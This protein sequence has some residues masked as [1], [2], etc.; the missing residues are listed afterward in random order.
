VPTKTF[1]GPYLPPQSLTLAAMQTANGP[2]SYGLAI[3]QGS[4]VGSALDGAIRDVFSRDNFGK[5][6]LVWFDPV[7]FGLV[8]EGWCA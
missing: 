7:W 2:G 6:R 5:V 4:I 1:L 8:C 3:Q